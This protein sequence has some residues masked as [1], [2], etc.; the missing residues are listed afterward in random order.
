MTHVAGGLGQRRRI[1]K[2]RLAA[3]FDDDEARKRT[4]AKVLAGDGAT[5]QQ[6]SNRRRQIQKWVSEEGNE[7]TQSNAD[8]LAAA[9]GLSNPEA[10]L[11]PLPDPLD[12]KIQ[13]L[14]DEL[15]GLHR[16]RRSNSDG[17]ASDG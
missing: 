1:D 6:I 8:A 3:L 17:A 10:F 12:A 4:I 16:Q 13:R 15:A 9:L 2:T 11:E 7:I 5:K 14:E